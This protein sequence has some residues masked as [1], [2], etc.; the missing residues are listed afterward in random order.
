MDRR[1]AIRQIL[2]LGGASIILP[3]C[4]WNKEEISIKLNH[5]K[6]GNKQIDL[7]SEISEAIIPTT[8]TPGAKALNVHRFVLRMVDDCFPKEEQKVFTAGLDDMQDYSHKSTGK[9]FIN[10]DQNQRLEILKQI[11]NDAKASKELKSFANS[12]KQLT[13]EGYATSEY[14]MTHR[15]DPYKL[16]PGHYYGCVKVASAS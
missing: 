12:V 10:S 2:L 5:L 14:A 8:D 15:K 16:V 4:N 6:I 3:S 11:E 7:I 9:S 13:V 1:V